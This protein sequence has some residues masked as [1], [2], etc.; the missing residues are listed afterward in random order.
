MRAIVIALLLV[1]LC[2]GS[3]LAYGEGYIRPTADASN[4]ICAVWYS[5]SM[6]RFD[7]WVWVYASTLGVMGVEFRIS[8][9]SNVIPSV[10]TTNPA[11]AVAL[12][13]VLSGISV[14][15]GTCQRSWVWTHHQT[16]Y[17]MTYEIGEIK[18]LEHP[19]SGLQFA[20]CEPGYPIYPL[21]VLNYL[22]VNYYPIATEATSWGAIKR[23][24]R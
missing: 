1:A 23:L 8:Y 11:V 7:T 13:D 9:P 20:S 24:F 19:S 14:A 5:G 16:C 6:T 15:F 10:V 17:L 4:S 12:G 18:I 21:R 22:Y 2:V 3:A